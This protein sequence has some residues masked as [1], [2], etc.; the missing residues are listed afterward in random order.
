MRFKHCI[1][2]FVGAIPFIFLSLILTSSQA[3]GEGWLKLGGRYVAVGKL[4]L[5]VPMDWRITQGFEN[6]LLLTRNGTSLQLIVIGRA[7]IEEALSHTKKRLSAR[8]LPDAITDIVLDNFRENPAITNFR[9][10][11]IGTALFAGFNAP[12]I[13]Y[14]YE[15]DENVKKMGIYSALL[16]DDWYYFLQYQAPTRHYFQRDQA[17]FD[18]VLK[19]LIVT[20]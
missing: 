6:Q 15:G 5:K 7:P 14:S 12:R 18:D 3:S 19:S 20:K 11:E 1:F 13:V 10:L 4:E 2:I 8:M 16:I 9:P 17:S